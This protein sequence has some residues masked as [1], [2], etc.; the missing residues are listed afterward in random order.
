MKR[1]LL[2]FLIEDQEVDM[3]D[4]QELEKIKVDYKEQEALIQRLNGEEN[5][6]MQEKE[7]LVKKMQ[8]LGFNSK[9]ELV[10]AVSVL[11]DKIE[12]LIKD[13]KKESGV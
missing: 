13:I 10:K 3:I 9:E 2:V 5:Q 4:V 1:V 7:R 11:E 8:G 6:L 12:K